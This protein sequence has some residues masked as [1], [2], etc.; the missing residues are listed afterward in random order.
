VPVVVIGRRD[1]GP[2]TTRQGTDKARDGDG[3]GK[4]VA[5]LR[6][7]QVPEANESKARAWA[8]SE[9]LLKR[10]FMKVWRKPNIPEVMAIAIMKMERSG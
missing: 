7:K 2:A 3:L 8:V 9:S 5:R 6:G 10:S 4:S 1:I